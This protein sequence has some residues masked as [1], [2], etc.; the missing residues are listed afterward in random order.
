MNK[1]TD[2][3]IAGLASADDNLPDLSKAPK[4]VA[5]LTDLADQTNRLS[6]DF[7]KCLER[8]H[9]QLAKR[10]IEIED[11]ADQMRFRNKADR[12]KHV[13]RAVSDARREIVNS[14]E[15]ERI[16]I[17]RQLQE[18]E[19]R[20]TLAEILF[21]GPV[22]M[23]GAHGLGDPK[24]TELEAQLRNARP[25]TLKNYAN[26]AIANKDKMLGAALL[27]VIDRMPSDKRPFS[28]Q[29]LAEQLIGDAFRQT[30]T[31]IHATKNRF[32]EA[33][34]ADRAFRNGRNNPVAKVQEALSKRREA[35]FNDGNSE[36]E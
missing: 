13:R 14:S 19:R 12:D 20:A 22:P 6:S 2:R 7:N 30:Q 28:A 5:E 8:N 31:A 18:A 29:Q 10:K 17:L 3:I 9:A 35:N 15:E 4:T 16:G 23:L 25:A 1:P 27:G 21:P 32:Q 26:H 24:R 11:A 34:N 33:I 36:Q